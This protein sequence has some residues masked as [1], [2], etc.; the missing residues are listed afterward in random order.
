MATK[1]APP[2]AKP[3]KIK[4][5]EVRILPAGRY[6][7]D[8]LTLT[9]K[10]RLICDGEVEI[11]TRGASIASQGLTT[12]E[13]DPLALKLIVSGSAVDVVAPF[14]G[15]IDAPAARM[16]LIGP[17]D[18]YG[19]ILGAWVATTPGV[20]LHFDRSLPFRT[21]GPLL[22]WQADGWEAKP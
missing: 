11:Y 2:D 20:A 6:V 19:A 8:Q 21:R 3:L 7:I 10:T 14:T 22:R 15:V 9:S 5:G 12:L 16:N 13:E 1:Q 4:Q 17:G 18:F